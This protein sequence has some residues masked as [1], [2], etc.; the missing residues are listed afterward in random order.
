MHHLPLLHQQ[1]LRNGKDGKIKQTRSLL[2]RFHFSRKIV[3]IICYVNCT[4]PIRTISNRGVL[5]IRLTILVI[6]AVLCLFCIFNA[7][8]ALYL[9]CVF[10]AYI[11]N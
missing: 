7:I 4:I 1:G 3:S 9:I 6:G 8:L 11:F 10:N 5:T 2:S